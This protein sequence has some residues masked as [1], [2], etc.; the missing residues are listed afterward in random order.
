MPN[1]PAEPTPASPSELGPSPMDPVSVLYVE[2]DEVDILLM[3]R[4]WQRTGMA[5][6]LHVVVDGREAQAYLS[7][8]A[9]YADRAVHPM[10]GLV[11]LDLKLPRVTGLELLQWIREQPPIH[12]LR[13]VILSS[14]S[15][16]LD[17]RRATALGADAYWTK[18]WDPRELEEMVGTLK[19]FWL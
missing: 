8:A 14:S 6:P 9:P 4:A 10:P 16:P 13:V 1:H 18:P 7:G 3:R 12:A 15:L 5:N 11:L 19:R 2:D 17:I